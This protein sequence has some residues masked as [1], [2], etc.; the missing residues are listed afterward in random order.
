MSKS[1]L[2]TIT[3]RK[4][5]DSVID[6]ASVGNGYIDGWMVS[7]CFDC[8]ADWDPGMRRCNSASGR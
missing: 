1:D 5:W 4:C 6:S 8:Q 7:L 2:T 3:T